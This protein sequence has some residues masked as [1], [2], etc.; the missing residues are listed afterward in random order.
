LAI[1]EPA[2][3]APA[4]PPAP[5][6]TPSPTPATADEKHDQ[7]RAAKAVAKAEAVTEA[8][9]Y[10]LRNVFL[11]SVAPGPAHNQ[12]WRMLGGQLYFAAP[13]GSLRKVDAV[14]M[15]ADLKGRVVSALRKGRGLPA[16]SPDG[17]SLL[18]VGF[19]R[20]V[21]YL[22]MADGIEGKL[23]PRVFEAANEKHYFPA[24]NTAQTRT[25]HTK[26]GKLMI[27]NSNGTQQELFD[28]NKLDSRV[29][30]SKDLEAFTLQ[31]KNSGDLFRIYRSRPDGSQ[32]RTV[33]TAA[34]RE[35][36]APAWSSDGKRIALIVRGDEGSHILTVGSDGSWPRAFF[37]STDSLRE[38]QWSPDGLKL[39]WLV[40]RKAQ[41]TQEAW[42]AGVEGLEPERA[43]ESRGQLSSLSWSPGGKHIAIQET[44]AWT[45][46]GLRLVKPDI[47]NVIMVDLTDHRAR[48]M[49]RY[50]VLA[51]Q[52]AFSPHGVAVAYLADQSPWAPGFLRER[53]A[54]L[55]ISQ[56]Y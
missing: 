7:A 20:D 44:S 45:F 26:A 55:V 56:L 53:T 43:F 32:E 47:N 34:G 40:D 17:Q 28:P 14:V 15:R 18:S 29:W 24:W 22:E 10:R 37:A 4:A 36:S 51:R 31:W 33:Y 27:M 25:L 41:G 23:R 5:L 11:A 1:L 21:R 3:A 49:T 13:A 46:L 19:E 35:V 9:P 2:E 42:T 54:D 30:Y 48:V 12:V 8:S 16:V 38:L 39:A 50:G 52:P 6:P